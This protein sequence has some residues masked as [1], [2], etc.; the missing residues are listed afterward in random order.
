MEVQR[1]ENDVREFEIAVDR[2]EK[3]MQRAIDAA[4][5]AIVYEALTAWVR[6]KGVELALSG[7]T[8]QRAELLARQQEAQKTLAAAR[9]KTRTP[10]VLGIALA[11]LAILAV[12]LGFLWLP[13]FGVAVIFLGGAVAFWFSFFHTNQEVQKRSGSLAQSTLELPRLDIQPL[14]AIHAR[15]PH[16]GHTPYTQE[17]QCY[18][19]AV[20]SLRE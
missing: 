8:S 13:A 19:L 4:R 9:A 2:A 18:G 3:N 16:V 20:R 1:R 17:L 6:L 12:I 14:R 15:A 11:V 10:L 5:R 7:Y